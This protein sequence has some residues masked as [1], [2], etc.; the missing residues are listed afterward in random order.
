MASILFVPHTFIEKGHKICINL[1]EWP[2]KSILGHHLSND[3]H[4]PLGPLA[5]TIRPSNSDNIARHCSDN[6]DQHHLP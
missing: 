2:L 6:I 3:H 4:S 1:S 5:I